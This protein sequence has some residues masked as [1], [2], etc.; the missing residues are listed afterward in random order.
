MKKLNIRALLMCIAMILTAKVS[1]V[2]AAPQV[3]SISITIYADLR[4]IANL[5][6]TDTAYGHNKAQLKSY[7]PSVLYL[8]G[9]WTPPTV[10][11]KGDW[12]FFTMDSIKPNIFKVTFK[13]APGQCPADTSAWYFAPTNDWSTAEWVPAPCNVSWSIQLP[14]HIDITKKD[15]T[16][17]FKYGICAPQTLSSIGIGTGVANTSIANEVS[18]FPN[19]TSDMINL[20]STIGINSVKIFDLTGRMVDQIRL[21]GQS[22]AIVSLKGLSSQMY[23]LQIQKT[24]GSFNTTKLFKR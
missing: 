8:T 18:I 3:D 9:T 14:F 6:G 23:L 15:T 4:D 17:V 5:A 1:F 21:K 20:K 12:T 11:G 16:A 13:Y 7:D 22:E 2:Y 19:P 10:P 24:D